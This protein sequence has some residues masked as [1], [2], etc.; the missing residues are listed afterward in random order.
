MTEEFLS[1]A[2]RQDPTAGQTA[3][4]DALKRE[5]AE[6]VMAS[7]ADAVYERLG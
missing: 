3:R 6:R 2:R 4:L 5:M 7:P 1:L